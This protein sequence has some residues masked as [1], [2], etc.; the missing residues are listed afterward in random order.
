MIHMQKSDFSFHLPEALIAQTPI[1]P[2]DHSR[3][4]VM[5]KHTGALT[6]KHFYDVLDYL[7]KGDLLVLND[8]RVLPARLFGQKEHTGGAMQFLLLQSTEKDIWEV[9]VKPGKKAK[10]GA[11]FVFGD[12]L[13]TGEILGDA[14][15][16]NRY[17]KFE[18]PISFI[19]T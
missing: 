17:V 1:E 3:M 15:G 13:L 5:D 7:N 12:G 4:L 19:R 18:Y 8:S 16:G 9:M 2:R 6:D 14:D 11:R 10:A